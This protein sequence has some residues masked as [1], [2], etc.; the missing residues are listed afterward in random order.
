MRSERRV[1]DWQNL[2]PYAV[3]DQRSLG[4]ERV[5]FDLVD[6]RSDLCVCE[7]GLNAGFGE[8]GEADRFC[9]ACV[10]QLL[11]GPPCGFGVFGQGFVD[12]VLFDCQLL[13]A[14]RIHVQE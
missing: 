11:H 3:F 13:I 12:D 4:Q 8:V 2:L 14:F 5:D 10:V 7:E 1:C 9:E 6:G